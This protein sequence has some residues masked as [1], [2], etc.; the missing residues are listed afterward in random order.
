[1]TPAINQLDP[2]RQEKARKY[3]SLKRRFFFIELAIA[4]VLL[5]L[6]VFGGVSI[7]ISRFLDFPQPWAS[8]LYFL[9]LVFGYGIIMAPLSYYDDFILPRRYGLLT[10]EL[11][12]WLGDVAKVLILSLLLG[13]GLVMAIY[14][15]MEHFPGVWWFLGAILLLL[16]SLLLTWLTPNLLL[17]LFFKLEPLKDTELRERLLNL[18]G[19]ARAQVYDVF[20]MDLSSKSPMANAM[21]AG[22]GNT[23]RIILSDTLLDQYTV[24]EAEVILAH[25]LSHHIHRDI[26]KLIGVQ[27]ISVLWMFYIADV[28]LKISLTPLAF[29]RLSDAATLPWLLLILAALGLVISPLFSALSR[30]L[31]LSADE[32]AL[33]LTDN[34][35]AFISA[36]TK[37]T[38]QNLNEAQPS[39]WVE[40]LFYDH[41]PYTKRVSLAQQYLVRT[42]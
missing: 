7:E 9:I 1:L 39:R 25:E 14:W 30:R 8:A 28:V 18:A 21:L 36:M 35:K 17:S 15:L 12:G 33:R 38:D 23:K 31:E 5:L 37:L 4:A 20:T 3:A 34:P 11:R 16:L 42:P 27:G 32:M 13:T 41:P 22:L 10:Q 40:L 24:E 2:A 26:P 19:R 6:L 29:S